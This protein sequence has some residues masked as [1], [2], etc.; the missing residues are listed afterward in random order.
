M[1]RHAALLCKKAVLFGDASAAAGVV[2]ILHGLD[3]GDDAPARWAV[4]HTLAG[5]PFAVGTVLDALRAAGAGG[6]VAVLAERAVADV[7]LGDPGC[8]P[9]SR[10]AA[11]PR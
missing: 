1:L 10:P 2:R 8:G 7:S 11:A 5:D 4:A 9:G 6:Q 3:P